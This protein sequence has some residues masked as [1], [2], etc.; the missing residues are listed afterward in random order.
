QIITASQCGLKTNLLV[1]DVSDSILNPH[2]DLIEQAGIKKNLVIE[3]Y[4]IPKKKIVRYI[5]VIF[6]CLYNWKS[7]LKLYH[8]LKSQKLTQ[9]ADF[10]KFFF[11]TKLNKYD[12]IHVQYGT[13]VKPLE[14]LKKT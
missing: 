6:L 2:K 14:I 3:D 8:F 11:L 5:K 4:N 13:N 9:I 10:Y 1:E 7:I 12:I